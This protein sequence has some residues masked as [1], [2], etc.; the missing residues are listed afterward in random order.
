MIRAD[1]TCQQE[2]ADRHGA[3]MAYRL[4]HTKYP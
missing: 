2:D 4:D 3:V 1:A